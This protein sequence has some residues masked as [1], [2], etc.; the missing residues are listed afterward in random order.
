V[1][2]P[3]A[4]RTWTESLNIF[5]PKKT[6]TASQPFQEEYV[7]MLERGLVEYKEEYLF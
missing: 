1:H 4:R 7:A 5:A 6:I 2:L 3:L